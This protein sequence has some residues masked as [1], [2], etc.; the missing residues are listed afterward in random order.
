V[1][2]NSTKSSRNRAKEHDIVTSGAT[3]NLGGEVVWT[4]NSR[5]KVPAFRV[6]SQRRFD[7]PEML[8]V[9]I[10]IM[11]Y[12]LRASPGLGTILAVLLLVIACGSPIENNTLVSGLDNSFIDQ[13][14]RPQDNFYQFANGA[15]LKTAEIP[16]DQNAAGAWQE[17]NA[18]IVEQLRAIAT[19]A[20]YKTTNKRRSLEQKIGDF[21]ASFMDDRRIEALGVQPIAQ[22]LAVISAI[23]S[24]SELVRQFV[25]FNR[26]G[27]DIPFNYFI[28]S[29]R[30]NAERHTVYIRQSGLGL[31]SREYYI[32][33]SSTHERIRSQAYPDYIRRLSLH[34]GQTD[35]GGKADQ[36]IALETAL[37]KEQ[38]T[39]ADSRDREKTYN[40]YK[41]SELDDAMP[42]LEWR[43][44]LQEA[45]MGSREIIVIQQP[46]YFQALA[47]LIKEVP[48]ETW[49]AF[50][51]F[52]LVD[53]RAP[54]LSEAV[55]GSHFDFYSTTLQNRVKQ[56][57]RWERGI[58]LLNEAIGHEIGR[59]WVAHHFPTET[60]TQLVAYVESFKIAFHEDIDDLEW[61]SDKTKIKA[62]E[63][64][65]RLSILIGYPDEWRDHSILQIMRDDLVGNVRR[66]HEFASALDLAKLDRPTNEVSGWFYPPQTVVSYAI[67]SRNQLVF[68]AGNLLPPYFMPNADLAANY[69]ALSILIGHE[70]S[71]LFDDQ[72]RR[73]DSQGNLADWWTEKDAYAFEVRSSM[74]VAQFDQFSPV[75]GA[76]ISGRLTLGENIAD[77]SGL[78]VG[79]RAYR[80]AL[81]GHE[82]L[83]IDGLTGNQRF[84]VARAQAARSL[85]REENVRSRLLTRPHA[86][87]Q[88]R[89]NGVFANMPEFY[90][91]FSVGEADAMYRAPKDRVKLW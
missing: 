26:T 10:R 50:L 9:M 33:E 1:Q 22:E 14:I 51:A 86:P 81:G 64:L 25:H 5:S 62:H 24:T 79:Y 91:A 75:E 36:I 58:E 65:N 55:A 66:A 63:K 6:A 19:E 42:E 61:M 54:Y 56:K 18:R 12:L 72:G 35:F 76:H 32:S 31:P 71:H 27:V 87:P 28:A 57:P 38:W 45:G 73:Y 8:A 82:P 84:F 59:L 37:A 30:E 67:Y 20:A 2:I 40:A 80:S 49:K 60:R 4:S 44:M 21:Y 48:L 11:S 3:V 7:P 77:L 83:V 41:V 47:R 90:E 78:T 88:F 13:N 53:A 43:S 69:G 15:W 74:L 34:A 68:S 85:R 89:V 39:R 23:S 16:A 17:V 29:D 52:K 70:I 46:T